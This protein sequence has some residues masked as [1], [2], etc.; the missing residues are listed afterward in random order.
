MKKDI[1]LIGSSGTLGTALQKNYKFSLCPSHA[2]LDI[3]NTRQIDRYFAT[4]IFTEVLLAAAFISPPKIHNDPIKAIEV[5]IIGTAN[6]VRACLNYGK[7][8]IYIS[9]DY[10][11]DGKKGNYT[12]ADPVFP[13]NKYAWSKLGGECSVRLIDNHLIIRTSFGPDVFPYSQAFVDQWTSRE[14]VSL[15]ANK[16]ALLLDRDIH[17][18]VHIGGERRTVY[19]YAQSITHTNPIKKIS[20]KTASFSVPKDTTLISKKY[21]SIIEN[22]KYE[23]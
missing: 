18:T 6:I 19:E 1:L 17:G 4:N 14:P 9:T 2:E 11:F 10:V 16:I 7:R 21:I 15:I 5:N 12:E 20:R 3:T 22:K 13:S 8:L 23:A